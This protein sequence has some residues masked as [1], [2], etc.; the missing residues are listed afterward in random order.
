VNVPIPMAVDARP[1]ERVVGAVRPLELVLVVDPVAAAAQLVVD[2][3]DGMA[4]VRTGAAFSVRVGIAT[5][6]VELTPM[7]SISVEPS[8][9][10][11]PARPDPMAVPGV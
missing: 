3:V 10:V 7:L 4:V 9:T 2:V 8:G 1:L 5:P 11:P 6:I